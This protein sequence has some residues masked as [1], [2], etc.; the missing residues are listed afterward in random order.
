MCAVMC[1]AIACSA[2]RHFAVYTIVYR[3]ALSMHMVDTDPFTCRSIAHVMYMVYMYVF[4]VQTSLVVL[5]LHIRSC[6]YRE[7][8]A[9]QCVMRW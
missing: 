8:R 5:H 2:L 6:M 4:T 3:N 7:L 9:V 1:V